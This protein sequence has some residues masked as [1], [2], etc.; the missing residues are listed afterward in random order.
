[1]SF[2]SV[3]SECPTIEQPRRQSFLYTKIKRLL[4]PKSS[5]SNITYNDLSRTF[6]SSE[7]DIKQAL[8]NAN[9]PSSSHPGQ[10]GEPV[11]IN[12]DIKNG[13]LPSGVNAS[14]AILPSR[15][16]SPQFGQ[17][18]STDADIEPNT[19][20]VGLNNPSATSLPHSHSSRS[21]NQGSSSTDTSRHPS[22]YNAI[23]D[24]ST[25]LTDPSQLPQ[26]TPLQQ[27]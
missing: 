8:Y 15:S 5:P 20:L 14:R 26:P 7:V 6:A 2:Y 9:Y 11:S 24:I 3:I 22:L 4:R 16:S 21:I 13:T 23:R 1:M 19:L 17:P 25:P 10:P 27:A 12:V 18:L